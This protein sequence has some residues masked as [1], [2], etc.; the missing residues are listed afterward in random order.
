MLATAPHLQ[1]LTFFVD[2]KKLWKDFKFQW[3]KHITRKHNFGKL[4]AH[5]LLCRSPVLDLRSLCAIK[6]FKIAN[7]T[8]KNVCEHIFC[9]DEA[10]KRVSIRHLIW[11]FT[12]DQTVIILQRAS[13]Q[14]LLRKSKV[15][16]KNMSSSWNCNKKTLAKY[17]KWVL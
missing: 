1:K 14:P 9:V 2:W 15:C 11:P 17:P 6:A 13:S 8:L 5:K 3:Q 12:R 4:T 16:T 7:L 10:T